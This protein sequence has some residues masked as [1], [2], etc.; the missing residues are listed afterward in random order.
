[1]KVEVRKNRNKITG[2]LIVPETTFEEAFIEA[3]DDNTLTV[4][5]K[6]GMSLDHLVGLVV[7]PKEVKSDEVSHN[8]TG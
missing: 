8:S 3:F 4:W 1:M 2:L 5:R 6:Y 7:E